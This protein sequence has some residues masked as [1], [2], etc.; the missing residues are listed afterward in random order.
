MKKITAL[1]RL[2]FQLLKPYWKWWLMFFG[3]A[4]FMG[5]I[6]QGGDVFMLS[7]IIFAGTVMAFPF[8]STDKS[9]L[10]VLY[11]ILPTNRKSMVTARYLFTLLLLALTL[12]ISVVVGIILD[13]SF[14][15]GVSLSVIIPVIC[16]STGIFAVS[17]GFQTPFFY[18]FGYT[19]GRIFMWIPI[20]VI[21]IIMNLQL[22]FNLFR[23][24]ISF[25][26][27]E[28]LFRQRVV[29][30][31]VSIGVAVT[32]LVVSFVLSRVIYLRRDV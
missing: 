31:L 4:L 10:H 17:V 22:V 6:N 2:D 14:R 29:T 20:V 32:A 11:S 26:I 18:R 12:V 7:I 16:I 9:N 21:M 5:L 15:N 3:I 1:L 8:E 25:N 28:I 30:S 23:L 13:L 27:F 24:D 19:K